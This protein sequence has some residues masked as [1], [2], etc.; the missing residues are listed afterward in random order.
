MVRSLQRL[1]VLA[2][3]G[4][5][6][7]GCGLLPANGPKYAK[8]LPPLLGKG[9]VF[10]YSPTS[11]VGGASCPRFITSSGTTVTLP[12]GS[13]VRFDLLPGTYQINADTSWCFAVPVSGAVRVNE[14]ERVFVRLTRK[15]GYW[16][17]ATRSPGP[18]N[19]WLGF[20]L[21]PA[22]TAEE[23]IADLGRTN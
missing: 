8:E 9:V 5:A 4:L 3:I 19:W 6:L 14:G 16:P 20:E 12:N 15:A 10:L 13:F 17:G 18:D 22:A 1:S 11:H 7:V 2:V 23:Q 21:I